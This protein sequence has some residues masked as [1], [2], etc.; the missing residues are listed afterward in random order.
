MLPEIPKTW[1][2]CLLMV[3]MVSMRCFGI[4][5]WTT[6]ALSII[7]GWLVG[8]KMEQSRIK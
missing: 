6:S 5:T 8:V 3:G 2:V 1:I 7:I 4:D